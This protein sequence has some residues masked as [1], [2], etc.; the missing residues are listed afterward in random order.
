M[1]CR[2]VWSIITSV[3]NESNHIF[4]ITVQLNNV[5]HLS[6]LLRYNLNTF[7]VGLGIATCS[8]VFLYFI[9][10]QNIPYTVIHNF[11]QV[12]CFFNIIRT[13]H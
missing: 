2:F 13:K 11:T 8:Q 1:L 9:S 10:A 6:R 5:N 12:H 3:N 4:K 7:L